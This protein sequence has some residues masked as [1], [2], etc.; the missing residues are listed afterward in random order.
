M[1]DCILCQRDYDE[2]SSLYG[3]LFDV[4]VWENDSQVRELMA[5]DKNILLITNMTEIKPD[6][7]NINNIEFS[8]NISFHHFD[9]KVEMGQGLFPGDIDLSLC[10][11]FYRE[12]GIY[13]VTTKEFGSLP[14]FKKHVLITANK[15]EE[16][17]NYEKALFLD[18]DGIINV[19][20]GYAHKPAELELKKGILKFLGSKEYKQHR[21]FIVTNQAGV[22]RGYFSEE[23]V[24]EFHH[25]ILKRL[26]AADI[27]IDAIEISPYH[28]EKGLGEYR[29]HS[30]TRKPFP[31]MILKILQ[32]Y[33]IDLS[34]SWMIGDKKSDHLDLPL[35]NY[36]HLK[37]DYDLE[38]AKAPVAKSFAQLK[39]I[40]K[41]F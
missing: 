27:S 14:D 35:L 41:C 8:G 11:D 26:R 29:A 1:I 30:L 22:A 16:F 39:N 38:G 12:S 9:T 34:K 20:T 18:R 32:N 5:L 3:S 19:D 28:F 7:F 21:K 25:E 33:R 2:I 6:I 23:E 24:S 10:E 17:S 13:L 15:Y 31:G 40:V 36:V 4:Q 37:G